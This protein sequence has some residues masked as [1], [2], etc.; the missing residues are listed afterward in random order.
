MAQIFVKD[1]DAS[2][3]KNLQERP[4]APAASKHC[5]HVFPA[6]LKPASCLMN[7]GYISDDALLSR[8]DF[9]LPPDEPGNAAVLS[10]GRGRQDVF[11][12]CAEYRRKEWNGLLYPRGTKEAGMLHLYASQ[13]RVLEFNATHYRIYPP[14]HVARWAAETAL[15][16]DFRYLPKFP[17]SIS[18]ESH[19]AAER[20]ALTAEFLESI[21]A[22]GTQLGPLFLQTGEWFDPGE[23]KEFFA[24]LAT[25]PEGFSYFVEL[26]HPGWFEEADARA[27][28]VAA[29]SDMGIGLVITDTPGR[30]EVC[31]M[32]LTIPKVML[33]FV[34]RDT[35][36]S[37]AA[38]ENEWITRMGHWLHAGL[39]ELYFICHTNLAAPETAAHVITQ[40]DAA[41]RR[42]LPLP[43]L[44]EDAQQPRLF[45]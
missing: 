23:R 9:A 42:H 33:R 2:Q 22:F 43:A 41:W 1:Q 45:D 16:P 7:F 44:H 28:L 26:R 37:T 29:L 38:R 14:E 27:D 6:K 18:H 34:A 30:R 3:R 32:I 17:Q 12:G 11:V 19:S 24:Y 8:I 21:S 10:R 15:R 36:P 35:H 25:L 13:F 20:A 39:D 31:H 40:M 4:S 5:R